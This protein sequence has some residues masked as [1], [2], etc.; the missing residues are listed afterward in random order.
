MQTDPF[1]LGQGDPEG[2]K[3]LPRPRG[4]PGEGCLRACATCSFR[5]SPPRR[6]VG[7]TGTFL[8]APSCLGH[9]ELLN[10]SGP[11]SALKPRRV[12]PAGQQETAGAHG[13]AHRGRSRPEGASGDEVGK[14]SRRGP[15]CTCAERGAR[16]RTN[17]RCLLAR[18]ARTLYLWSFGE[19]P[20][21][22][23]GSGAVRPHL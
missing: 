7:G 11:T 1:L 8:A 4:W 15:G 21:T 20:P 14:G 18:S 9:R 2:L 10:E 5:M 6:A 22:P 19:S 13:N 17:C 12:G 16:A 23:W 3:D